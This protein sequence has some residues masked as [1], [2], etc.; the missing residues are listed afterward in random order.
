MPGSLTRRCPGRG[1]FKFEV[2]EKDGNKVLAKTIDNSFFQRATVF[3]G[4]PGT[5]N[6]TIEADS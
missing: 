3:L 4:D 1:A 2:R 6:Y 5:K